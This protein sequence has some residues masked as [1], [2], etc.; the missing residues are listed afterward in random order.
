MLSD[1]KDSHT[2]SVS[3]VLSE[4]D[5][6]SSVVCDSDDDDSSELCHSTGLYR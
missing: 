1:Y 3:D 6:I 4:Y 5:I 2:G